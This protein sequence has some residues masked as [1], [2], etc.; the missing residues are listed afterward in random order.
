MNW[1]ECC[2]PAVLLIFRC[3]NP[4]LFVFTIYFLFISWFV[5]LIAAAAT[6]NFDRRLLIQNILTGHPAICST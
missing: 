5:D 4:K 1:N 2:K 6:N 3:G